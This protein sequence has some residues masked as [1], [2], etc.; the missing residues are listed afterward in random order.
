[1]LK[2][3]AWQMKEIKGGLGDKM[4]DWVEQ[5]DQT[6]MRLRQQFR[7]VQNPLVRAQARERVSLRSTHPDVIA[8]TNVMNA[9]NKRSFPSRKVTTQL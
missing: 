4:E 2:H 5:L 7:T 6:G 9:G 8:H 1:M 3:V